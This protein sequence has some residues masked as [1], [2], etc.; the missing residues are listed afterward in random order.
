[1]Y[2]EPTKAARIAYEWHGGQWSPLY[3]YASTGARIWS[4]EHKDGL[5]YDID[6]TLADSEVRSELYDKSALKELK[7]L[8]SKIAKQVIKP[9][10]ENV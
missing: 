4:Q 7:W 10:V 2:K 8:R 3:S 9:R 5:L 6:K 1:M